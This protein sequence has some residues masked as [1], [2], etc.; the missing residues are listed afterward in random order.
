MEWLRSGLQAAQK[1]AQEAADA[2]YI[3]AQ[4]ASE[5][6]KVLAT[7]AAERAQVSLHHAVSV[8]CLALPCIQSLEHAHT[9]KHV[10]FLIL[11]HSC[12]V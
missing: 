10:I 5:N 8:R 4:Q 11:V 6:A 12:R 1:Q 9:A 3:L 7:Q 2:A